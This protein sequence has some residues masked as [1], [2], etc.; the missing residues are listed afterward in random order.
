MD[1]QPCKIWLDKELALVQPRVIMAMGALAIHELIGPGSVEH[2]HGKPITRDDGVIIVP[3]YHPAAGLYDTSIL[4]FI[5]DDF[6]VLRAVISGVDP[7]SFHAKDEHPNPK[8]RESLSWEDAATIIKPGDTYAI[9]VETID[10][11]RK[12]WSYQVSTIPGTAVFVSSEVAKFAR[13]GPKSALAVAH[14]YLFDSKFVNMEPFVD[15]MT[16]AYLLGLPQ[17]LKELASRLCGMEMSSYSDLVMPGRRNK[18]I[19]YLNGITAKDWGVADLTTITEWNN[20]QGKIMTRTKKPQA[21]NRKIKRILADC[22]TKPD[23]DPFKRWKDIPDSERAMVENEAGTMPD[24]TLED[25]PHDVAVW[26]SCRDADATLRVWHVVKEQRKAMELE[27]VF[28]SQDLAVLPMIKEMMTVGMAVDLPWL[29]ALS[30]RFRAVMN[31]AAADVHRISG[32]AANPNSSDQVSALLQSMGHKLFTKTPTG[33]YSTDDRELKQI[34]DPVIQPILDYRGALK[35]KSTYADSLVR[36]AGED[37]MGHFWVKGQ[38]DRIPRIHTTIKTTRTETGRLSSADPNL[39]NIPVR[40]SDGRMIR[41]AFIARP[42][43]LLLASDY[44]QIEMRMMAHRARCQG[45]IDIF[46]SGRDVHTE[47]AAHSFQVSMK[48][49][50]S[51]YYRY[52]AKRVAFGTIYGIGPQG[53]LSLFIEEGVEHWSLDDCEDMLTNYYKLYP[54]IHDYQL[55]TIAHARRFGYVKDIFGRIRYIPEVICPI[56]RIRSEGERMACNMPIQ[57]GAQG[58]IKLAMA[59]LWN[60]RGSRRCKFLMQIHDEVILEVPIVE[61]AETMHWVK[62]SMESVVSLDVPVLATV[63]IGDRW[64]EL[65]EI[66]L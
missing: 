22:I 44:S 38:P 19:Q 14:N 57:G 63:K 1:A 8:Y 23:V 6:R 15:T 40:T 59:K 62:Q 43:W 11:N 52:P 64:G 9:D 32:I 53:L 47:T 27:M 34:K 33:K 42:G 26:Y 25:I 7:Q 60:T 21:I 39:Q 50:E 36:R 51:S 2:L 18:A 31:R 24:A 16:A 66:K 49:A 20:K 54:E 35:N 28:H 61:M 58:V 29:Q 48:E 3:S 5:Y 56:N 17:G 12:M 41:K 30:V 4:R 65:K 10:S 37:L 55:E 13:P 45:L 46:R